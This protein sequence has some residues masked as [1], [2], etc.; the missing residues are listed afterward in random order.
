MMFK[1]C[2]VTVANFPSKWVSLLEFSS[3]APALRCPILL[4]IKNAGRRLPAALATEL[5]SLLREGL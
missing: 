5:T 4:A 1:Y 2:S 3:S